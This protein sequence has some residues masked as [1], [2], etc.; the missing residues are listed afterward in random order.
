MDYCLKL[1]EVSYLDEATELWNE[2]I[3]E[4][5]S[6]PGDTL[7]TKEQAYNMFSEQTQT[8]CAV[9]DGKVM[10]VYILH[11]NGIGRLAHIANASFAV[12]KECRGMGL[13][14]ALV[15]DS[16]EKAK[17]NGFLGLQFNAVVASN[18]GA[19]TLYLKLGFSIIGTIKNGYRLKD[20]SHRDMLI[21]L[22]T[23]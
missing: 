19:I 15:L 6:F 21:F 12:K 10:G 9:S 8:V 7:L 2:I 13:G 1:F 14:R 11:P 17:M 16:I 5:N 3:E 20:G 18:T 23:W 22:K 4:A